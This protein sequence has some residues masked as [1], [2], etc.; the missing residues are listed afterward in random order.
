MISDARVKPS[1][2][3]LLQVISPVLIVYR[4][5]KGRAMTTTLPPSEREMTEI[6][7]NNPSSSPSCQ[8]GR[9]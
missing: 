7:F 8:G 3:I 4:I 1:F 9:I 2:T 6:R 5:A